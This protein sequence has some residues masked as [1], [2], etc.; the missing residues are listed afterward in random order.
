[1]LKKDGKSPD[2]FIVMQTMR[3]LIV[4]KPYIISRPMLVVEIHLGNASKYMHCTHLSAD[5]GN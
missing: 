4:S 3:Y 5:I 2:V 1:M